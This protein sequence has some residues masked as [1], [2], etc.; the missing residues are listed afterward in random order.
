M[1]TPM[2]EDLNISF[3]GLNNAL[4][5]QQ[6]GI[7]VGCVFTIPLASKFGR[8][9][10]YIATATLVLVVDVWQI[11]LSSAPEIYATN[12]LAGI[13]ASSNEAMLLVTVCF[14]SHFLVLREPC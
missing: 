9:P 12:F 3:N 11:Y 14:S 5:L 10:A 8:R 7:T 6:A 4:A 2:S 1:W 13:A